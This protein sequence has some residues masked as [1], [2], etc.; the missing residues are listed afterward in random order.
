MGYS[1]SRCRV[2]KEN[3]LAT[4]NRDA[5]AVKESILKLL[6][7]IKS[8]GSS[9]SFRLVQSYLRGHDMP[10]ASG[11]VPLLAK[12]NDLNYDAI[13][14][15]WDD[16]FQ[17]LQNLLHS[18]I[19]CSSSVVWFYEAPTE[20][21]NS[22]IRLLPTLVDQSTPFHQAFP[23]PL[24][25]DDLHA[26]SMTP[27]R[28]KF[29]VFGDEYVLFMCTKR[30]FREREPVSVSDMDAQV[31]D[32]LSGYDELIGVRSGYTQA[33]D[34]IVIRPQAGYLELHI[35][36]CCT[37]NTEELV[38]YKETYIS[39]FKDAVCQLSGDSLSWLGDAKNLFPRIA[40]LYNA[41][42]GRVLSLGHATGTK[43]IKEERMRGRDLDLREELFHKHGIN[44]I[45]DTD[46]YSIKKGWPSPT[47]SSVPSAAIHGHFSR[48][49]VAHA[50]VQH[51]IIEN[52]MTS[53]DF[54]LV[55]NKLLS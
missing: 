14:V 15:S 6:R 21:L 9:Y 52:C 29:E 26:Q 16:Y 35:D 4:I 37:L 12:Y 30:A 53:S 3:Y 41:Q 10:S 36:L 1:P 40:A 28:T 47:G 50:A 13:S 25:E 33:F 49:G 55:R 11:W 24:A 5:S 32:A 45:Q 43:S 31:R 19:R 22:L 27:V 54:D 17:A 44:A 7:A 42:D 23:Y 51:A 39:R 18:A 20:E 38:Q 46:A 2:T 48:A 8:R 34:R